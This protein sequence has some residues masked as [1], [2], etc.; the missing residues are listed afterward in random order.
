MNRGPTDQN[1]TDE[2]DRRTKTDQNGCPCDRAP[3]LMPDNPK[4]LET[5]RYDAVA[6]LAMWLRLQQLAG[7][8]VFSHHHHH[9]IY[10]VYWY[11]KH[12]GPIVYSHH[13]HHHHYIYVV[14]WYTK[15]PGPIVYSRTHTYTFSPLNL[16]A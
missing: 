15:H 6:S 4:F 3:F 10:V 11:T 9:H 14:Y 12:P 5:Y 2:L 7:P 16:K 8:I 13:H 1:W